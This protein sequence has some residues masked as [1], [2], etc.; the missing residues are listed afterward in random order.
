M[1][2]FDIVMPFNLAGLIAWVV[3]VLCGRALLSE[4]G[5]R[6]ALAIVTVTTLVAC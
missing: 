4:L 6:W 1:V 3:L 5:S 2:E